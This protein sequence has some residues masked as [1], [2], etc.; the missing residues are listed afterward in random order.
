MHREKVLLP[1][2]LCH[3]D[4]VSTKCPNFSPPSQP[5]PFAWHHLDLTFKQENW[6]AWHSQPLQ[7]PSSMVEHGWSC[8]CLSLTKR[9]RI[10]RRHSLSNN[11]SFHSQLT[12]MF[13]ALSC[14]FDVNVFWSVLTVVH[15]QGHQIWL[16]FDSCF[17]LVLSFYTYLCQLHG[18]CFWDCTLACLLVY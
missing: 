15:P 13:G 4:Y 9:T 17:F 3:N 2:T 1:A 11:P 16:T 14:N 7:L 8:C 18:L 12:D 5:I 10:R 6:S